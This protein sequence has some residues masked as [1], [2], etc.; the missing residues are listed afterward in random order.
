MGARLKR[1]LTLLYLNS[2]WFT[3]S[4]S[5]SQYTTMTRHQWH[6][7]MY[8]LIRS[9]HGAL[10]ALLRRSTHHRDFATGQRLTVPNKQSATSTL[11]AA[12]SRMNEGERNTSKAKTKNLRMA[13]NSAT[14]TFTITSYGTLL[15]R[16][17]SVPRS[18]RSSHLE[19]NG[20]SLQCRMLYAH[21]HYR[22]PVALTVVCSF[23]L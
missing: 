1:Q 6:T 22:R 11:K 17:D 4:L 3:Y 19:D 2:R 5:F 20:P 10:Q 9:S 12:H 7:H 14:F 23:S 18:G 13:C 21:H 16:R 15:V 8:G